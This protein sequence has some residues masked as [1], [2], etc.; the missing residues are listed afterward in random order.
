MHKKVRRI[1]IRR[2]WAISPET[3]IKKSKKIYSRSKRKRIT[4]DE[5]KAWSSQGQFTRSNAKDV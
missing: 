4:K 5:V 1:K 2:S 3:R